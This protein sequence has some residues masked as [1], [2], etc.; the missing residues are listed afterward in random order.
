MP[1]AHRI[2]AAA[3]TAIIV[4]ASTADAGAARRGRR[5]RARAA[6]ANAITTTKL[7][8]KPAAR[9]G[10][11]SAQSGGHVQFV[12]EK[13][14]YLDRGSLDGVE[15][16]QTLPIFRAGRPVATCTIET[17]AE[18]QATCAGGRPRVG[19]SFRTGRGTRI[20]KQVVAAPELPP[21][22]DES[23]LR[24]RAARVAEA[25]YQKVDFSGKPSF[26]AHAKAD[27]SPG[28]AVWHTQSDPGRDY[29]QERIDGV[30]Q[31]LELGASGLRF[32]AAF[33]AMR[34][35]TPIGVERFRPGTQAQFY[36]WEA[37]M[38]RRHPDARTVFAAGR[39][40][41]WHSPG[42]TL[43]DGVQ[44]GRQ[45]ETQTAEAGIYGGL[46]PTAAGLIPSAD[47]WAAGAYGSLVEN[48]SS[49]G[50]FHLARQ[51]GRLG[52][53]RGPTTDLIAE[54]EMLA[55]VW[56]GPWNLGGGGRVRLTGGTG[57]GT[58]IDRAYLDL[59]VR[60]ILALAG[61]VHLRYFGAS[62][63]E[64]APLRAE[65]P[66]LQGSFHGVADMH[67]DALSWVGV[68]GLA[69]A[70]RDRET[71]RSEAHGGAE[72][73]FPRLLG[74]VGGVWFGGEIEEG[75]V[76][77]RGFYVQIVGHAREHLQ[78]LARASA[79][80]NEFTTPTATSN[81]RELGGYLH[82][83][84]ALVSWLRVRAWTLLRVPFLVQGEPP[85]SS[86]WG[87]GFGANLTGLF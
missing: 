70:H 28:L 85:T 42:L 68:A 19:D 29:A 26:S 35:R 21:L 46:I 14:V 9:P 15:V 82:V 58:G 55:Q 8:A 10:G 57:A 39:L 17:V 7:V 3:A 83:D 69:G 6:A 43:L 86:P 79:N 44:L 13:R 34:W 1:Q 54:A 64:E 59:G 49:K 67:W 45:N 84:G 37:E 11:G 5:A 36:L 51:E 22:V 4:V 80:A 77:G 20:S 32:D 2:I 56:L 38:S 71:N 78:V 50:L 81:V 31:A 60:P 23:T 24:T 73:R 72:L 66:T 65:T 25:P 52:I 33:S 30:V 63:P 75:W 76:R 16:H 61:G 47:T 18:H 40:W 53:W 27:V 87:L 74:N 62:L 41:P 12:T 48:G